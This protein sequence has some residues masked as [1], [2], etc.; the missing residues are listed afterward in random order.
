MSTI[1][2]ILVPTDF[3]D[4][5]QHALER[6]IELAKQSGA[7]LTLLH[8]YEIPVYAYSTLTYLSADITK[9]VETAARAKLDEVMQALR[10]RVPDAQ[11]MLS[12]GPASETIDDAIR[13]GGVD[14]VVMGT[15]G[16]RGLR[17]AML[18]SV[19]ER[20]IRHSPVPVLVVPAP[21]SSVPH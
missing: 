2:H 6:A 1:R 4:A 15:H 7:K 5:A 18:G 14:M 3:G 16:R 9:A 13:Q 20:V 12:V 19:A 10:A 17:H 11:S 21:P 8:V